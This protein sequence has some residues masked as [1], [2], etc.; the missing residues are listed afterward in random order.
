LAV[1]T[2]FAA[3]VFF[4]FAGSS[5]KH[6]CFYTLFHAAVSLIWTL[7]A[8]PRGAAFF[9]VRAAGDKAPPRSPDATAN[10][11]SHPKGGIWHNAFSLPS[12]LQRVYFDPFIV[13]S[14]GCT[15]ADQL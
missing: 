10:E 3:R 4:C 13:S 2:P 8:R 6:V 12:L 15:F 11:V 7:E 14:E 5:S 1:C 9:C